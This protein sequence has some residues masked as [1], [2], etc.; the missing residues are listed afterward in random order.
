MRYDYDDDHDLKFVGTKGRNNFRSTLN[1]LMHELNS[2][3]DEWD[4]EDYW[5]KKERELMEED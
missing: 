2:N 5:E 3:T 4:N 1:N